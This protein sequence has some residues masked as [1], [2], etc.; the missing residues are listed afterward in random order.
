MEVFPASFLVSYQSR[1]SICVTL[2]RRCWHWLRCDIHVTHQYAYILWLQ[3][4]MHSDI[5]LSSLVIHVLTL[6]KLDRLLRLWDLDVS[7][8]HAMHESVLR[9]T[10]NTVTSTCKKRQNLTIMV[11]LPI[12]LFTITI[13]GPREGIVTSQRLVQAPHKFAGIP[14]TT[15]RRIPHIVRDIVTAV[16]MIK[17]TG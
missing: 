3:I 12:R 15:G 8:S 2:L 14:E 9:M 7:I 5:L 16:I 1:K 4:A 6:T 13:A 17:R 10:I 11:H